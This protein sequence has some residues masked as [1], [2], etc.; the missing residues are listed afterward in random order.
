MILQDVLVAGIYYTLE[1]FALGNGNRRLIFM[2][3]VNHGLNKSR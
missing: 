1:Y 2:Q 3:C